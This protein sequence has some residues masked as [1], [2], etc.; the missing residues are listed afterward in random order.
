MNLGI[1]I[2]LPDNKNFLLSTN[3]NSIQIMFNKTKLKDDELEKIKKQI[4]NY[5]YKYIHSSYQI[6]IA[7]ELTI[8][9][10]IYNAS[11]DIL[12]TQI[13]YA[14][15]VKADGI[16][17]HLGKNTKKNDINIL[18]NNMVI[19]ILNILD[20]ISKFKKD[21]ILLLETSSGQGNEIYYNLDE[22]I[23]LVL[24][25]KDTKYYKNIAICIDTCHIYQAGYDLNK[26]QV[27]SNLHK[28]LTPVKDKIKLI[29]LNNSLNDVGKR[30]DR[31][32]RLDNGFIKIDS[33]IEFIRPYK[34]I[35]MILETEPPYD[36]QIN[37]IN[38]L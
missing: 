33:L 25:F 14:V 30:I 23:N 29:H 20:K 12:L 2:K 4:N 6:N 15:K 31:H 1:S 22:F 19:F 8:S 16:V 17:L 34:K 9:N 24:L 26:K 11:L 5:R 35:P 28:I 21:F 10:K 36:N 18:H 7:S 38:N 32:A 37:L 3:T 13:K 27:I